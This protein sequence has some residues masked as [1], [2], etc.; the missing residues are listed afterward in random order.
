MDVDTVIEICSPEVQQGLANAKLIVQTLIPDVYRFYEAN[1]EGVLRSPVSVCPAFGGTIFISEKEKG[2]I[3]ARLHYPVDVTE[4]VSGLNNSVGIAFKDG[5]LLIAELGEKRIACCDLTGECF[6]NPE[7]KTVKQLRKA[8][9]DRKLLR[10]GS[11]SKKLELQKALK[12]WIHESRK[13]TTN[14]GK[15]YL[16]LQSARRAHS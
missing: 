9:N 5:L 10:Q 15:W 14:Y 13:S 12:T 16:I 6:L 7:K 8:L 3:S 2:K 4:V 1:K 11:R